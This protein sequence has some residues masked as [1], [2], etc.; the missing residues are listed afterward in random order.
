MLYAQIIVAVNRSVIWDADDLPFH[1]RSYMAKTSMFRTS[2]HITF[3]HDMAVNR[4]VIWDADDLPF[5]QRSYM[6]K[7]SMFRTSVHITF[8]HDMALNR[9]VI[10]DAD[11]LP[12]H[13]RSYMAK[14]SMF[15]TSVHITF[16]LMTF[17]FTREATWQ[18]R[19]CFVRLFI[20]HSYMIWP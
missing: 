17:H 20:S 3:L 5:H 10:W 9:S 1:Q 8:L 18:R 15:R 4:S 12:F 14:T 6:A 11:D 16:L 2:V 13:Q 7:T 19:A